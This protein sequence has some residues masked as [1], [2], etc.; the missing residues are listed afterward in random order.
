MKNYIIMLKN[1]NIAFIIKRP[2]NAKKF[3]IKLEYSASI[4]HET[5]F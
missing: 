5:N 4:E 1:K 2:K 3:E